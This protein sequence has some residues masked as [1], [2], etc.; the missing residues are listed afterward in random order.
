MGSPHCFQQQHGE[1]GAKNSLEIIHLWIQI[2]LYIQDKPSR[3]KTIQPQLSKI[4]SVT[5]AIIFD[6][7]FSMKMKSVSH[8][9]KDFEESQL[10]DYF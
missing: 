9:F 10:T 3:L 4:A 2:M 6:Q 5:P 7:D 1:D 8:K